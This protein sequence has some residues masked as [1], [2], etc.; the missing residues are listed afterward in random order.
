VGGVG[1]YP[2]PWPDDPR[3]DPELLRDGEPTAKCADWN[4]RG[5]RPPYANVWMPVRL[6]RILNS[7]S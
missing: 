5:I 4:A 3:L 7:A 1:P 6:R 2:P